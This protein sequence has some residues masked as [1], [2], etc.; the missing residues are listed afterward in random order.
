MVTEKQIS[1]EITQDAEHRRQRRKYEK[2]SS[3]AVLSAVIHIPIQ[4]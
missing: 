1:I 3:F 4:P 2:K